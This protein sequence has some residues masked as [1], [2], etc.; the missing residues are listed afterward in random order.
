MKGRT[1][2]GRLTTHQRI[3]LIQFQD[4][5]TVRPDTQT[6]LLSGLCLMKQVATE[7]EEEAE[8]E[9]ERQRLLT[10]NGMGFLNLTTSTCDIYP[11]TRPLLLTFLKQFYYLET[12][13]SNMQTYGDH[14]HSD[15]HIPS[16]LTSTPICSE[17]LKIPVLIVH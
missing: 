11:P 1:K 6:D 9:T 13:H 3:C 4:G 7:W 14:H 10:T 5:K 15:H 12:K 2:L 8:G 16:P 17:L